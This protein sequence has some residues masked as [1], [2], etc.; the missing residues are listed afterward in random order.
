MTYGERNNSKK[1]LT[2]AFLSIWL[3]VMFTILTSLMSIAVPF[4][5]AVFAMNELL[6]KVVEYFISSYVVLLSKT[7]VT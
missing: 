6:Y 5:P 1:L 4:I 7:S 2:G 3:F